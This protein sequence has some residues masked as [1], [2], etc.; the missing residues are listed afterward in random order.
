MADHNA[1]D[2]AQTQTTLDGFGRAVP[3]GG[4]L[5]EAD[6]LVDGETLAEG[7]R[8]LVDWSEGMGASDEFTGVISDILC[9]EPVF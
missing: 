2:D 7:D 6:L 1:T 4:E 3:D 9:V 8:V 5:P